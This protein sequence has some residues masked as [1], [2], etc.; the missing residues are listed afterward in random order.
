MLRILL[1]LFSW[2]KFVLIGAKKVH[3]ITRKSWRRRLTFLFSVFHHSVRGTMNSMCFVA[4]SIGGLIAFGCALFLD[5]QSQAICALFV[6]LLYIFAFSFVLET[7]VFLQ[8]K[9]LYAVNV[10]T[11]NFTFKRISKYFGFFFSVSWKIVRILQR[12]QATRF[13]E[14]HHHEIRENRC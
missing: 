2:T 3:F 6:P 8:Q 5:Y 11:Q 10:N 12:N 14:I 13:R 9:G 7:P 4:S 1:I